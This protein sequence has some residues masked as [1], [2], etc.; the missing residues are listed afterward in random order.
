MRTHGSK[1]RVRPFHPLH[2]NCPLPADQLEGDRITI[3]FPAMG[4]R[5]VLADRWT[6][7]RTWQRPGPWRGYT[8]LRT[9]PDPAVSSAAERLVSETSEVSDGSYEQVT[10]Q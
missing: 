9:V 2:R 10:D 5:E 4:G 6:V 1:G 3:V 8:L 7:Q